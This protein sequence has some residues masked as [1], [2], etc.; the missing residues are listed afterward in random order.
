MNGKQHQIVGIGFGIAASVIVLD[1][2]HSLVAPVVGIGSAIGCWLPDIDH[3]QTKI[4]RVRKKVTTTLS[5]TL[6]II[7]LIGITGLGIGIAG[8]VLNM[9]DLSS[10]MQIMK[11]LF[12][13]CCF[14]RAVTGLLDDSETFDWMTNHRGFMHT[15]IPPIIIGC[16]CYYINNEIMKMAVMGINVGYC[17]H[18]LADSITYSKVPLLFPIT[19]KCVG[20]PILIKKKLS[21]D[22]SKEQKRINDD[23]YEKKCYTAAYFMAVIAV[24]ISIVYVIL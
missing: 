8:T 10:Y 7:S 15:L 12:C 11:L 5:T 13:L 22:A 9:V 3:N 18:L 20:I 19:K 16:I 2:T 4:G 23:I 17:S 24:I 14:Y 1:K 6:N 21:K